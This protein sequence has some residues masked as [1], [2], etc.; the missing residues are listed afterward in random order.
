MASL[1][2]ARRE[3]GSQGRWAG[4]GWQTLAG[5]APQL[6]GPKD[7]GASLGAAPPHGALPGGAGKTPT[8]QNRQERP[9]DHR[10]LGGHFPSI[11]LS[12]PKWRET[13]EGQDGTG[14]QQTWVVT[15][16]GFLSLCP[17]LASCTKFVFLECHGPPGHSVPTLRR[18]CLCSDVRDVG[19]VPDLCS[20]GDPSSPL[21]SPLLLGP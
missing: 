8:Q 13:N 2:L 20:H 12:L 6:T 4:R 9:E 11:C 7:Q 17:K 14:W 18:G 21:W 16:S 10:H 5:S 1:A 15:A 19:L 3:A